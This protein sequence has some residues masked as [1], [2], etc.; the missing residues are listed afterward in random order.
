M[1]GA[2]TTKLILHLPLLAYTVSYIFHALKNANK[3][4]INFLQ[5]RKRDLVVTCHSSPL[6]EE[7]V[8]KQGVTH[9]LS[10]IPSLNPTFCK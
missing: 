8:K 6:K 7:K 10:P 1:S 5:E 2:N 4:A 9:P 3:K